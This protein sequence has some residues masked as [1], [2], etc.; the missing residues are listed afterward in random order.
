VAP[1][2]CS[3]ASTSKVDSAS[4]GHHHLLE[5]SL[6]A[7]LTK[8][9]PYATLTQFCGPATVNLRAHGRSVQIRGGYCDA[10]GAFWQYK[11]YVGLAGYVPA[12]PAK[13]F[14]LAVHDPRAVHGGTFT[15]AYASMQLAGQSLR[16]ITTRLSPPFPASV[17]VPGEITRGTV[18]I[19]K[20]LRAGTF[21]FHLGDGTAITGSWTCG[22]K[23]Y[24]Y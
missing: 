16:S 20:S 22:E 9:Q 7:I 5:V 11:L 1:P 17:P 12:A 8:R 23:P 3:D 24:N 15:R 18:T 13:F 14:G 19:A 2:R 10:S 4:D 6:P 21:V